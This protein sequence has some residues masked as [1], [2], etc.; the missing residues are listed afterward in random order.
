MDRLALVFIVAAAVVHATW[1]LLAKSMAGG[2]T[3]VWSYCAVGVALY[4]PLVLCAGPNASIGLAGASAVFASG[5]VHALYSLALQKAYAAGDLSVVYPLA[6]GTAPAVSVVA[7]I[8]LLGEHP[9]GEVLAGGAAVV[10]GVVVIAISDRASRQHPVSHGLRWGLLVG[11]LVAAY[12]VVDGYA[13]RVLGVPPILQQYASSCVR[14]VVL[15]PLALRNRAD[16]ARAW[17]TRP[18]T[19]LAVGALVPVSYVLVLFAI[20]RAP[21]AVVAPARELSTVVGVMLGWLV[22]KE[23]RASWRLAGA[24]CI[25]AGVVVLAGS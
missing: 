17:R 14:V 10:A 5:C 24:A 20:A 8:L 23:R 2:T 16:L 18:L 13:V 7:A 3:F 9:T 19:I 22:L 11:I 6:R 4:A 21:L 15:L 1:N 12:T 25:I